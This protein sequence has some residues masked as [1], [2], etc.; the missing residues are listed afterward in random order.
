MFKFLKRFAGR[1]TAAVDEDEWLSVQSQL[2]SLRLA[3]ETRDQA[4][5]RLKADLDQSRS[6]SG[7]RADDTAR[8]RVARLMQA[9][10]APIAQ[11]ALQAHLLEGEGKPVSARDVLAV[12]QSLIR[13]LES[14]GLG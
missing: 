1:P 3:L 12:A 4:L 6:A 5:V 9:A 10:A 7:H 14:E 11:L 2:R 8:V 13:V